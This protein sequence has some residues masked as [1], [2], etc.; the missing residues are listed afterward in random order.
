MQGQM[1][2]MVDGAGSGRELKAALIALIKFAIRSSLPRF[3]VRFSLGGYP[4]YPQRFTGQALDPIG[5]A[6]M[7]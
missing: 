7:L 1:G 5:P 6:H 2:V 3:L 4:G